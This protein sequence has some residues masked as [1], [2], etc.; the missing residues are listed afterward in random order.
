[1]MKNLSKVALFAAAFG[2][3]GSLMAQAEGEMAA[4][5]AGQTPEAGEE[6]AGAGMNCPH[7]NPEHRYRHGYAMPEGRGAPMGYGQPGPMGYGQ[8]GPMGYGQGDPMGYGQGSPMG[9]GP[10]GPMGH[11][12]MRMQRP[13]MG[14]APGERTGGPAAM[15]EQ[16]LAHLEQML[17]ISEEQQEAWNRFKEAMSGQVANMNPGFA[18]RSGPPTLD[19][20]IAQMKQKA[21][22]MGAMADALE[23]VVKVLDEDQKAIFERFGMSMGR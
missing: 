9:Y 18:E 19:T 7:G 14:M 12:P 11:R 1:M 23:A 2:I 3:S 10:G 6:T 20:R 13:E 5:P 4:P 15:M 8:G 17:E 16:R 21:G 22:A